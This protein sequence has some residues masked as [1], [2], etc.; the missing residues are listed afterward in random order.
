MLCADRWFH[1]VRAR[2]P[3]RARA[4][5]QV[6]SKNKYQRFL[7]SVCEDPSEYFESIENITM[8][9]ETLAAAHADLTKRV[10]VAQ[11]E[12]EDE[13]AKFVSFVKASQN[14]LLVYNSDI[15]KKQQDLDHLRY[16]TTDREAA[17]SKGEVEA[18][19]GTRQLGE[20]KM[21]I[22]NIHNR[23]VRVRGQSPEALE[24]FLDAI[25]QRV[26][27]LQAIVTGHERPVGM[28][29]LN[30]IIRQRQADESAAKSAALLAMP[31]RVRGADKPAAAA[32]GPGD[33]TS[34]AS[35]AAGRESR[36]P[37][38]GSSTFRASGTAADAH[39]SSGLSGP[40]SRNSA[41]VA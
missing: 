33:N 41:I 27:D 26:V 11:K 8:R 4:P 36:A 19:E 20:I 3:A 2:A 25:K 31:D 6:E 24:A 10:D 17:L 9:Y 39:S 22:H 21:A 23:C 1:C 7:D 12:Q 30:N 35:M 38:R 14:D 16:T 15:A 40:V 32:G 5:L 29:E 13:N 28:Q 37:A 34:P 18:K